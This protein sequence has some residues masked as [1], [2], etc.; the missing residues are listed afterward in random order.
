MRMMIVVEVFEAKY[1]NGNK[2]KF[3]DSIFLFYFI[4]T[5]IETAYYYVYL[6]FFAMKKEFS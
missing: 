3:L 4:F 2:I 5:V 6:C 1:E